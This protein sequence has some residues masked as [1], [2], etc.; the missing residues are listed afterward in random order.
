[1]WIPLWNLAIPW[2]FHVE[3]MWNGN[4]EIFHMDSIWNGWIPYGIH[5]E[6]GGTVKYWEMVGLRTLP[7]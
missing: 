6:C 2:S 7:L 1:M 5:M 3:S 4:C